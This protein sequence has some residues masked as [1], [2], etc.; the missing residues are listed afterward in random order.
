MYK[1]MKKLG[2]QGLKNLGLFFS[3]VTR[4]SLAER[5]GDRRAGSS[6]TLPDTHLPLCRWTL[7]AALVHGLQP[8]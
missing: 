6:S 1:L 3:F 7:L 4:N 8:A 2:V 5:R